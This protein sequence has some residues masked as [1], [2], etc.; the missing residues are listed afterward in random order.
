MSV[1]VCLPTCLRL[2]LCVCVS[3]C[4]RV[5]VP[6]SLCLS[7]SASASASAAVA[8]SASAS[9]SAS[10][11]ACASGSL[12]L[13]LPLSVCISVCVCAFLPLSACMWM[14]TYQIQ[15]HAYHTY[16]KSQSTKPAS[17]EKAQSRTP[18]VTG[19]LINFA[20]RFTSSCG[21]RST[22]ISLMTNQHALAKLHYK[23]A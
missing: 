7:V 11:S 20:L 12:F 10:G 3:L 13:S 23:E 6:M 15:T 1:L 4:L 5:Y 16:L 8:A 17:H 19:I 21:S 22:Y 2:C 14:Y 9:G 18:I